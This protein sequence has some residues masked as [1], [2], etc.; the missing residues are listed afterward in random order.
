MGQTARD[1]AAAEF[2]QK[3]IC[4]G[5]LGEC[6]RLL[7]AKALPLPLADIRTSESAS[8]PESGFVQSCIESSND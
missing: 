4:A 8:T 5:V 7:A 6:R 3:V 2:R 1:R